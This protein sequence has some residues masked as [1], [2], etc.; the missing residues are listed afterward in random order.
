MSLAPGREV[1]SKKPLTPQPL[2]LPHFPRPRF[3]LQKLTHR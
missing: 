3:G 2:V 1:I